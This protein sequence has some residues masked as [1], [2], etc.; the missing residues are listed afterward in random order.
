M[1]LCSLPVEIAKK[2]PS[3]L[4]LPCWLIGRL[5]VDTKFQQQHFGSRLLSDA[6]SQIQLL[7]EQAGG[8]CAVVDAKDEHVKVFYEKYGFKPVLDDELRLY[9]PLSSILG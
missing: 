8:Y 4:L 6:L 3:N 9:L 2:F 5:A 7:A 1:Q